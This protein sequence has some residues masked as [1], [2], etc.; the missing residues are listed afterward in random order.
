MTTA[1]APNQ[2][3]LIRVQ[4]TP[5]PNAWKFVLDRAVLKEGKATYA[6]ANES[7]HNKLASALFQIPE[8][9][10]VHFFQN[11]ITITHNFDADADSIQSQVVSVIQTRFHLHNPEQTQVD[12]KKLARQNLPVE[13]QTIEEI[14]DRTIRPGLQGDGG[15]LTVIKY[16]DNKLYVHYEGACGTCPS[17]TTGTLMAIEGLL[18]DEFNPQI[19]VIPL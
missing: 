7:S 19:E 6:D 1:S 8:V 2:E 12:E 11:V 16:E 5:N 10:Q 15:D 14:L 13:V 4:A 17:S 3:I 18:R 9:R